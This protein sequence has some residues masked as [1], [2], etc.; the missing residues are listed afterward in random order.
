MKRERS[1]LD[2]AARIKKLDNQ[3]RRTTRDLRTQV[4]K[5]ND[6]ESGIF[7]HLLQTVQ[8]LSPGN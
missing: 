4:T 5:R 1:H 7:E 3:F 8:N 6:V 2:A